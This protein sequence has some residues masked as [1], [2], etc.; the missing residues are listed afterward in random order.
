MKFFN[1]KKYL[2]SVRL[3]G[4]VSINV[5]PGE[6]SASISYFDVT[7]RLIKYIFR[8]YPILFESETEQIK[9]NKKNVPYKLYKGDKIEKKEEKVTVVSNIETKVDGKTEETPR[10]VEDK[11]RKAVTFEDLQE[12]VEEDTLLGVMTKEQ[13]KDKNDIESGN[14]SKIVN[15]PDFK[16]EETPDKHS[17][18]ADLTSDEMSTYTG[19]KHQKNTYKKKK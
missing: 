15:A 1:D 11:E 19:G 12:K 16:A 4:N 18:F 3:G 5:K 14:L 9:F 13:I 6:L 10:F 7:K 8:N 17:P 2:A